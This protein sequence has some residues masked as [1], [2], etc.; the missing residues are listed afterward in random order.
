M[1]VTRPPLRRDNSRERVER[2]ATALRESI[3]AG[4]LAPDASVRELPTARDFGVSQGT[5]R[6][7]LRLLA[8]EGLVRRVADR[9]TYVAPCEESDVL[10]AYRIRAAVEARAASLVT[11]A[12]DVEKER[13]LCRAV[14]QMVPAAEEP[15]PLRLVDADLTFHRRLCE[16]ADR[17]FLLRTWTGAA[18]EIR[19]HKAL[20]DRLFWSDP[21]AIVATHEPLVAVLAAD[22][23]A[24]AAIAIEDHV[25]FAARR[26][27]AGGGVGE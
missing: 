10:E 13:I 23:G 21:A 12:W 1:T 18:A 2:V 25:L 6:E 4:E 9:G 16:L 5:V 3:L 7:A 20:T 11:A 19:R 24:A 8:G 15:D 27:E 26:I 14:E 22:D 17:P